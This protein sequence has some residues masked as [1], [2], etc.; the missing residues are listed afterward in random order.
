[1]LIATATMTTPMPKSSTRHVEG[2]DMNR[3]A[4]RAPN[5][6]PENHTSE[7]RLAP[8]AKSQRSP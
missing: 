8:A 6:S 7:A 1:M 4:D 3:A 5:P 2:R